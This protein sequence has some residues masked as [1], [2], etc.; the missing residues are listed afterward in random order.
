ME[1]TKILVATTN[2]GKFFEYKA[3]LGKL[4]VEIVSPEEI[5]DIEI[6][7]FEIEETGTTFAEN[8][9]I[10]AENAGKLTGLLA[11]AD[12]SGLEVEALGGRPGVYSAR[13]GPDQ[14]SRNRRLLAEMA[15]VPKEK[16]RAKFVCVIAVYDPL[17]D[18]FI[19]SRG[20][21][22]GLILDAP[23]G[24]GGFGY[25]P[26]FLSLELRR[27]FA[28]SGIEDKNRVSHRGRALEAIKP[29]LAA[30]LRA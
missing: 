29:S 9:R 5:I 4:P 19:E 11:L 10:K 15:G 14:D 25:D 13:Y 6:N 8:A 30:W 16:R 7:K 2:K 1:K 27:T 23:R 28:E 12:D 17:R 21:S 20:E 24:K 26:L 18:K 22:A 3:V